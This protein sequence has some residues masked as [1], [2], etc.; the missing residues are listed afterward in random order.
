MRK[1][2]YRLAVAVAAVATAG[3]FALAGASAAGAANGPLQSSV[4]LVSNGTAGYYV[5]TDGTNSIG[6]TVKGAGALL[7]IGGANLGGAGVQLCDP[8]TNYAAQ[9]GLV[10]SG[11]TVSVMWQA[12]TLGGNC[13]GKGV[14]PNPNNFLA[15]GVPV[16]TGMPVSDVYNL[17]I[18]NR[19]LL[20]HNVWCS[21]NPNARCRHHLI[22]RSLLTFKA[23]DTTQNA[24]VFTAIKWTAPHWGGFA[25]AGAGIQQ[26]LQMVSACGPAAD[27]KSDPTLTCGTVAAEAAED[28]ADAFAPLSAEESGYDATNG[29][30]AGSGANN[31]VVQFKDVNLNGGGVFSSSAIGLNDTVTGLGPDVQV[32]TSALALPANPTVVAPDNTLDPKATGPSQFEVFAGNPIG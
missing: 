29:D 13:V 7:N 6:A 3:G 20:V 16:L 27:S 22:F 1:T 15:A 19:V 5:Q 14:L 2:M 24:D 18:G 8:N 26:D 21:T 12:G 25:N 28:V 30:T 17:W 23:V 10:P 9:L 32:A 4:R 11:T 31:L